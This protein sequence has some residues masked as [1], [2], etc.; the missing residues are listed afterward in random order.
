MSKRERWITW[1]GIAILLI[2]GGAREL[3]W[4]D[5]AQTWEVERAEW[6][7][8]CGQTARDLPPVSASVGAAHDAFD[9]FRAEVDLRDDD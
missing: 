1:S 4:H 3:A 5:C 6:Q 8:V 2:A 7:E 9:A